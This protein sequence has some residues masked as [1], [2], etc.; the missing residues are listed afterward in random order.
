MHRLMCEHLG[1]ESTSH[2]GRTEWPVGLVHE[3]RRGEMPE[4]KLERLERLVFFTKINHGKACELKSKCGGKPL[5]G[6]ES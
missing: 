1:W 3:E 6:F 2:I 4:V 5:T